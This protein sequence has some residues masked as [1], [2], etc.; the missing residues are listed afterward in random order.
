MSYVKVKTDDEIP[1]ELFEVVAIILRESYRL[2]QR[3]QQ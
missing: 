2:K 1:E 3:W